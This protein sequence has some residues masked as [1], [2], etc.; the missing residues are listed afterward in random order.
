MRRQIVAG[1][2]KMNG[3]RASV[4]SLLAG[5]T[6]GVSSLTGVDVI[7]FPPYIYIEFVAKLLEQTQMSWGAQN[8]SPE[9]SGAFTGE[10]S[11]E[12]LL[13]FACKYVIV[14]H[15]ERRSLFGETNEIVAKKFIQAKLTGLVPILCLGETLV[16]RQQNRTQEVVSRQLGA[17]LELPNGIELLQNSVLA[18]EPVWAIGTGLT[19]SPAQAQEVHLAIRQQVRDVSVAVA[20]TLPIL[21]GGSVKA[22]NAAELF[23]MPDIDGGLIGGASLHAQEFLEICHAAKQQGN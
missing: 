16:E 10:I 5:L 6:A 14:G 2:W 18:Y 8:L 12:M 1:N 13:D 21:Y 4:T 19:A 22:A 11:A 20:G 23:A 3:T 9:S 15:S 17:I 7:V